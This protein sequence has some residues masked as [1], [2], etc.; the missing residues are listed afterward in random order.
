MA[1]REL[2]GAEK[3]VDRKF[4]LSA[5]KAAY[6]VELFGATEVVPFQITTQKIAKFSP[7]M[8]ISQAVL[9]DPKK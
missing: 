4:D 6:S 1:C 9:K 5:A 7:A 8:S 3:S 2:K